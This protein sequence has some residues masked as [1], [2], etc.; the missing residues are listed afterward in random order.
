M[1]RLTQENGHQML[2]DEWG[3]ATVKQLT[4]PA[5]EAPLSEITMANGM[6]FVVVEMTEYIAMLIAGAQAAADD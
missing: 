6:L 5:G 2:V 3:I 4:A 1:I